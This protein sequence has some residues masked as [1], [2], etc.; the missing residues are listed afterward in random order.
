MQGLRRLGDVGV[1]AD[2]AEG[3][4]ECADADSDGDLEEELRETE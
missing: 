4:A 2:E 3:D 1:I